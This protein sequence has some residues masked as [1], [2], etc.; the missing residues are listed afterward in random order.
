MKMKTIKDFD[1]KG[2]RVLVR[3]DFDVPLDKQGNIMDD[4]KIQKGIPT[5]KYLIKNKA[6]LV[7]M[8]HLGRPKG[9]VVESLRVEPVRKRL[10]EILGIPVKEKNSQ[11]TILENLRFDKRERGN[12]DKFSQELAK[13][14]DIYINDA[15]GV[16]HRSHASIV[17]IPKYLPSGAGLLLEKE[18]E[19]LSKVLDNPKRPLVSVIGGF[20][21][22]SKTKV[23]ESFLKMSDHVLIGGKIANTILIVKR[24]LDRPMPSEDVVKQVQDLILTSTKL[25]LPTDVIGSKDKVNAREV[26]VAKVEKDEMLL[27]IGPETIHL[28][29]DI[30]ESAKTIIWAGPLGYFE[31][32]LF[33]QGTKKIGEKIANSKAFKIVGGG[34]T[35]S[36][37]AKYGLRD[38][39]DHVS[40]GGGSMLMFLAGDE[41]P[42]LTVLNQ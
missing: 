3:C 39:F 33:E 28:F 11:V 41:L 24:D 40:T 6:K 30:I 29:A 13:L 38:K 20:K 22:S 12:D 16:C 23:I 18:I 17:G 10:S 14:G 9:K 1:V 21:L 7:L 5:I 4:F 27:D 31:N 25:H 32:A 37:L 2:K 35:V 15:F 42:G 34:D 26:A 8:G 36:A 19:V